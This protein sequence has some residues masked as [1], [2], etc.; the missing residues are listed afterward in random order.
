MF[1]PELL[2]Q[3]LAVPRRGYRATPQILPHRFDSGSDCILLSCGQL[4]MELLGNVVRF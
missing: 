2:P 1:A 4:S 3:R